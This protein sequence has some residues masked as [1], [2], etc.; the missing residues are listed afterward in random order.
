MARCNDLCTKAT[1]GSC[2]LCEALTER[3]RFI[4]CWF[5][6]RLLLDG[7]RALQ[8]GRVFAYLRRYAWPRVWPRNRS[9]APQDRH[10]VSPMEVRHKDVVQQA[11]KQY[12]E[13]LN[14]IMLAFLG[15]AF[16]CLLTALGSADQLFLV[17]ESPIKIPFAN[18]SMTLWG[19]IWVAPGLLL[20]LAIYLHIFYGYWID[21]EWE[22]QRIN[23]SL[24][25]TMEGI[26]TLFSLPAAFP[27]IVTV[28]IFYWLVPVVLGVITWKACGHP[29]STVFSMT[30]GRVLTY[31]S[32]SVTIICMG[33]QLWRRPP[34]QRAGWT[35]VLAIIAVSV[36]IFFM[37]LVAVRPQGCQR[38]LLLSH[39]VLSDAWLAG[40]D[41]RGAF[42]DF[43]RLQ[44]ANLQEANLYRADL[45][46]ANFQEAKLWRANLQGAHLYRADLQ[47][48]KFWGAKL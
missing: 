10:P 46:G 26:P 45:R 31:F 5:K 44:K 37:L 34:H 12:S 16:F 32:G 42:L 19:F 21:C 9:N 39:A 41:M 35:L 30:M 43:A 20:V 38:P 48:A 47:E 1:T 22:R 28:L 11:H 25:A 7:V 36:A 4:Q 6:G 15:V 3:D 40:Q 2:A 8:R 14:R 17:G 23:R 24:I 33:L 18:A 27:H 29:N 13:T